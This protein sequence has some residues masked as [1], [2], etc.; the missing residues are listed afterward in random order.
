MAI[1]R[2]P[3]VEEPAP[4]K[5]ANFV[6][7]LRRLWIASGSPKFAAM[8][9]R[10]GVAK[11]TLN[12]AVNRQDRLPSERVVLALV[13]VLDPKNVDG[14]LTRRLSLEESLA[15]NRVPSRQV[16]PVTVSSRR[17][18]WFF[19]GLIA[20]ASAALGAVAAVVI[21]SATDKPAARTA[22]SNSAVSSLREADIA[23][24]NDPLLTPCVADAR[25]VNIAQEK[26]IGT[27]KL[28]WSP[29]CDAW[30][31]RI[32]RLDRTPI[33]N[34]VKVGV[35]EVGAPDIRDVHVN[36]DATFAYSY[37]LVRTDPAARICA[38]GSIYVGDREMSLSDQL[39]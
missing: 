26:D 17:P 31:A 6:R 23:N 18:P 39:C 33:G 25:V 34:R 9:A 30:W 19:V 2:D 13:K 15:T 12:D 14:W 35:F 20:T 37:M 27:L 3:G 29:S 11:T 4:D 16:A 32:E 7:D 5:T 8:A 22:A 10:T 38:L 36:S 21:G 1:P 24:G 28:V